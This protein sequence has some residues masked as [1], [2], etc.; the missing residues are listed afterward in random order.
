M[1][2]EGNSPRESVQT[3]GTSYAVSA[4][5]KGLWCGLTHVNV[6]D[7]VVEVKCDVFN[8]VPQ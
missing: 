7:N 6:R 1:N 3:T 4:L 5:Q 2:T 8:L